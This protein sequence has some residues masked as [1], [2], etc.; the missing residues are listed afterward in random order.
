MPELPLDCIHHGSQ[1]RPF[2]PGEGCAVCGSAVYALWESARGTSASTPPLIV[3]V[4]GYVTL[5]SRRP[6]GALFRRPPSGPLAWS[7]NIASCLWHFGWANPRMYPADPALVAQ[8]T[9]GCS[10]CTVRMPTLA[11]GRSSAMHVHRFTDPAFVALV[12]QITSLSS[13]CTMSY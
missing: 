11:M 8:L 12:T 5:T 6:E 13:R 3:R 2:T 9:G 4:L 10:C 7:P 1:P